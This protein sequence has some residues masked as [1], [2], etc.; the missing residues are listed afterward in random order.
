MNVK[1]LFVVTI[2]PLYLNLLK[3]VS[4]HVGLEVVPLCHYIKKDCPLICCV[5]YCHRPLHLHHVNFLPF[6][7]KFENFT[8]TSTMCRLPPKLLCKNK[9]ASSKYTTKLDNISLC[10][11][12]CFYSLLSVGLVIT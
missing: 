1:K 5:Y 3:N 10:I 2:C 9:R 4:L 8:H 12:P 7:N 11:L 6:Q